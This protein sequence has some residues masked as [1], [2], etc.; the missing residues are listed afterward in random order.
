MYQLHSFV[1]VYKLYFLDIWLFFSSCCLC[2][3]CWLGGRTASGL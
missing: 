3:R 1:H 2:W